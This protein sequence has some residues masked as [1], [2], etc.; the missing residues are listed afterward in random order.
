MNLVLIGFTSSGKSATGKALAWARGMRFK[1]LDKILTNRDRVTKGRRRTC[2]EIFKEDGEA[3]FRRA[4]VDAI[5]SLNNL[6]N[7]VLATGGGA[8]L[9]EAARPLLKELGPVIYLRVEPE[10]VMRRMARKGMPAFL[11]SDPTIENLRRF[12]LQRDP[13]YT[14]LADVIIDSTE[15]SVHDSVAAINDAL[16]QQEK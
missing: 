16:A 12:W 7:L 9:S 6:D 1:D 8:P 11:A 15:G 5:Q 13:V 10:E 14:E 4:E 3:A 2:R